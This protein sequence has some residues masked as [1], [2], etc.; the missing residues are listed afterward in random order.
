MKNRVRPCIRSVAHY[1]RC[2]DPRQYFHRTKAAARDDLFW[3]PGV[4][5]RKIAIFK[6]MQEFLVPG[7]T[8]PERLS[9]DLAARQHTRRH[10][11]HFDLKCDPFF[12]WHLV[13]LVPE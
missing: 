6:E 4:Y 13:L 7:R 1:L 3:R 5:R 2:G 9:R 8:N 10:F 11:M 12:L